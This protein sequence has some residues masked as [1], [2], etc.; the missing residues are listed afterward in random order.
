MLCHGHEG[1]YSGFPITFTLKSTC[2]CDC[3][4]NHLT[5]PGHS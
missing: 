3:V 1:I 2:F 5:R 4:Q